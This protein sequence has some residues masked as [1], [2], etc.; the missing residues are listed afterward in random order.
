MLEAIRVELAAQHVDEPEIDPVTS[1]YI[2]T[3]HDLGSCRD[4]NGNISWDMTWRWGDAHGLDFDAKQLLWDV[5]RQVE[6][7]RRA[8]MAGQDDVRAAAAMRAAAGQKKRGR[9]R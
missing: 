6:A 7:I 1:S 9:T 3:M 2:R 4:F 8:P 5:V